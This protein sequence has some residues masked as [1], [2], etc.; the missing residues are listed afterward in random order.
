MQCYLRYLHAIFGKYE[1]ERLLKKFQLSSLLFRFS[2]TELGTLKVSFRIDSERY[3]HLIG[4]N[5][6]GIVA[7]FL[8]HKKVR[9]IETIITAIEIINQMS[10][11]TH[12]SSRKVDFKQI[13]RQEL[14]R[15]IYPDLREPQKRMGYFKKQY[16]DNISSIVSTLLKK[17]K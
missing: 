11:T 9:N 12:Y 13:H 8:N 7:R 6:C 3:G 2:D 14:I 1:A 10:P 5:E 15:K 16:S 17:Y 4:S